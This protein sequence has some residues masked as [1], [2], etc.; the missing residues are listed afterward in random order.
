MAKR[1][2]GKVVYQTLSGGF[3][4]VIGDNGKEYRPIEMPNQLKTE[5]AR[6][7]IV[8]KKA[9]EEMSVYMWGEAVEVVSF[10]TLYP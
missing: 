5:G 4:G 7:S 10:S 8:I 3:W 2:Q 9:R 6:V 1:I